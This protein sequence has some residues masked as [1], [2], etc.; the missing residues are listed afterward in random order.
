MSFS[1]AFTSD[2]IFSS[3][4]RLHAILRRRRLL[5][6]RNFRL[7]QLPLSREGQ[8]L[9]ANKTADDQRWAL[10]WLDPG[11]KMLHKFRIR[12]GLGLSQTKNYGNFVIKKWYFVN[13]LD[14]I[15]TSIFDLL[16]FLDYVW[17][18]TEFSKFRTGSQN[19]TVRSSPRT[20]STVQGGTFDKRHY[21]AT[22]LFLSKNKMTGLLSW[23]FPKS[24]KWLS[25]NGSS[26]TNAEY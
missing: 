13:C 10:D 16:K 24:T 22:I 19:M 2:A 7:R 23:F 6:N 15:W 26:P 17:T 5:V 11:C 9:S 4:G 12:T 1:K 14:F 25:R 20:M 8:L 21:Q 18:W 3:Y